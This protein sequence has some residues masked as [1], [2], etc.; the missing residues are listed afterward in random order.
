MFPRSSGILLHLSSLPGPYGIG[1]MG[2]E[3]RHFIRFL[4]RAGQSWW[5]V[6]PMTAVGGSD[7]PYLPISSQA[8]NPL[9]LDLDA[10]AAMKLLSWEDLEYARFSGSPDRVDFPF[11][12]V[13]RSELLHKAWQRADRSLLAQVQNFASAHDW[14]EDYALFAALRDHFGLPLQEWPDQKLIR[15]EKAALERY[16]QL[17]S[18]EIAYHKFVQYLFFSQWSQLRDYA[19]ERGVSLIGDIPIYVSPD[20]VD[21][22]VYPQL[23]RLSAGRKPRYV[24][25]LPG[26]QYSDQG[27]RWANPLYNWPEHEKT[28]F[29][30]W[31]RRV[32]GAMELYD[33]VRLDHFR[34]LADYWEI[35]AQA[36]SHLMGKWKKG[37]GMKLIQALQKN[38][39]QG[40]YL[41]EDLGDLSPAA[42]RFI[43]QAGLPGMAVLADAFWDTEGGSDFLPHRADPSKVIYTSTHD[44]PTFCQWYYDM[45]DSRQRH[46]AADYLRI[47][48]QDAVGWA[49]IAGAWHSPCQ[50]AMAPLQD[51][52]CLGGDS[53]M[54]F[55][56][57]VG[58]ANWSWRVRGEALNS[59]VAGL[60]RHLTGLYG[61]LPR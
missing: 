23:F 25:G 18:D 61:R 1:S 28:G 40:R 11:L 47:S 52:L 54:N 51:A 42:L 27:Q 49:A 31:C 56:G 44:T 37:P 12:H 59:E 48:P 6:L 39:P 13:V 57:T 5:Q 9:F 4:Q 22:W 10:L 16:S 55:P 53:R 36:E 34:A 29:A 33:V 43:Q 14:L 24:G 8:G 32:Q 7:C 45:A 38:V 35:P 15:R 58:P 20:S 46:Y 26:D 17:L 2:Q 21:V 41:V 3:A 60:L 30:W 19:R 50:L